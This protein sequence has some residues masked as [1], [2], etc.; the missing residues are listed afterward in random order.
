[1]IRGILFLILA[2]ILAGMGVGGYYVVDYLFLQPQRQVEQEI[3]EAA[4]P[5][6]EEPS[7]AI[8]RDLQTK[9][10]ANNPANDLIIIREFL[11]NNPKSSV[12]NEALDIL[13]TRGRQL[14]FTDLP[15][16]WKETYKVVSGDSMNR[17]STRQKVSSDWIMQVNNLLDINMQVGQELLLPKLDT[18]LI[19]SRKEGRLFILAGEELIA[20]YPL[21]FSGVPD[22]MNG[23]TAVREKIASAQS[24]RVAFGSPNY[25]GS[26]KTITLDQKGIEI[27]SL[28]ESSADGSTPSKSKGLLLTT[29][30]MEEVFLL[31]KKGTPVIIE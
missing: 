20:A 18:R 1:M 23:T 2:A 24:A 17:I 16:P 30:D 7:K 19:A 29:P 3:K 10:N 14:L 27:A 25:A 13:T 11:N 15:A 21:T 26:S 6:P 22:S 4:M 8:W 31:A 9:F 28:P 12:R 5:P